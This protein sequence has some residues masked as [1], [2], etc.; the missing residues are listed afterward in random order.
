MRY[1]VSVDF[2]E[3]IAGRY[4]EGA[5]LLAYC[6]FCDSSRALWVE[7]C[8]YT[9]GKAALLAPDHI[10]TLKVQVNFSLLSKVHYLPFITYID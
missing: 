2:D 3:R 1:A 7:S 8:T 10:P 4:L 9:E 6:L 5:S